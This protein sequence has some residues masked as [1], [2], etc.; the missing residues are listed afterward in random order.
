MKKIS[1][2]LLA[3]LVFSCVSKKKY[4]AL[5]QE[6]GEI[7]S[8]LQKTQVE[9]EDLESKFAQIEAR[10]DAYNAKITSLKEETDSKLE[11]KDGAVISNNTKVKM[12]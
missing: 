7:K 6:N 2:L 8:E 5:E 11:V 3:V 9:K 12:R 10:V 4:M 1:I